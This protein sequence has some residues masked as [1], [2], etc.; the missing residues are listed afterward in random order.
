[1]ALLLIFRGLLPQNNMCCSTS[2]SNYKISVSLIECK[3]Q[4]EL[5]RN[6]TFTKIFKG[7]ELSGNEKFTDRWTNANLIVL[8]FNDMSTP[9]G[10]FVISQRKKQEIEEIVEMM[11]ER[12]KKKTGK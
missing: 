1:M 6:K 9:V 5:A 7:E 11:K 8:G 2:W 10:H 4:E 12:D 3:L